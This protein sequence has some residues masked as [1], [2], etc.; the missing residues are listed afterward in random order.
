MSMI[1]CP[2]CGTKISDKAR[3]C[4]NCGFVSNE[5][6][7]PIS[8]QDKYMPLPL[9]K[10][11]IQEWNPNGNE[12]DYFV[13]FEDNKTLFDFLGDWESI[14]RY[15]PEISEIISELAKEEK[16]LVADINP[17][18]RKLIEEGVYRFTID[19]NGEILPTIRDAKSIV[20]QVRLKEIEQVPELSNCMNNLALQSTMNQI[21]DEIQYVEDTIKGLHIEL[22]ND[23]LALADSAKDQLRVAIKIEDSKLR[24]IVILNAI[25]TATEAKCVLMRNFVENLHFVSENSDLNDLQLFMEGKTSKDIPAKVHDAFLDLI[26]ITNAVQIECKGYA[27]LGE[28]EAEKECLSQFNTFI[29]DNKLNERDTLLLLN[30]NSPE[31]NTLLV[32]EFGE[33]SSKIIN[34]SEH[35]LLKDNEM[36][37][38]EDNNENENEY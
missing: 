2:E 38:L 24:N 26:N 31:S 35:F 8:E 20:K 16:V 1:Q 3:I 29:L 6:S 27:I 9:F 22:Q 19:K 25:K 7:R 10:Y 37:M 33:I 4:P 34:H 11:D 5:P 14:C 13:S 30:E 12:E 17:Y 15:A 18:V 32:N 23:R 36:I 28:I 21:L